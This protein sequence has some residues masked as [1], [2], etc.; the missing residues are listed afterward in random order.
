MA[1]KFVPVL[2]RKRTYRV[3]EKDIK[4]IYYMSSVSRPE[5]PKFETNVNIECKIHRKITSSY[6]TDE[7]PFFS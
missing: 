5:I 2:C 3:F 6:E 7:E 4:K 1:K